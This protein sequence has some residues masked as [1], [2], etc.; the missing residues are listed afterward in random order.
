MAPDTEFRADEAEVVASPAQDSNL[1]LI[2][3]RWFVP[4]L[5]LLFGL[6]FV[7]DII[8]TVQRIHAAEK[9]ADILRKEHPSTLDD[10][11]R[12]LNVPYAEVKTVRWNS[13]DGEC[14]GASIRLASLLRLHVTLDPKGNQIRQPILIYA[15]S[16]EVSLDHPGSDLPG[17]PTWCDWAIMMALTLLPSW[18][19]LKASREFHL[20]GA[21][22]ISLA[23][24]G[25]LPLLVEIPITIIVIL[26]WT[27]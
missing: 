2:L 15:A 5:Y 26:R 24:L 16:E 25:A 7:F 14:S 10:L 18:L 11:V 20:T 1:A 22:K 21:L 27:S 23:F 6:C 8:P 13:E 17:V 3:V 9:A 12:R 19:W 4:A